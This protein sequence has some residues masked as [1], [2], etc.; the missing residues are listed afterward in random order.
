MAWT[1]SYSYLYLAAAFLGVTAAADL[2]AARL[3]LMP[4]ALLTVAWSRVARPV[5]TRWQTEGRDKELTRMGWGSSVGLE[6]LTLAYVGVLLLS[7]PLLQQYVLGPQY[8]NVGPLL[9]LWGVYFAFNVV[10][11]VSTTWLSSLGEYRFLFGQ[12]LVALALM[13]VGAAAMI[14]TLGAAGA[15]WALIV[16]EATNMVIGW[17]RVLQLRAR[18]RRVA[19]AARASAQR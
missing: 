18:A 5:I 1:A 13:L 14:P 4:V 10:R 12:S 9:G 8:H 3:L 19:P 7:F 17:W 2:N 15:I 16:V 6:V 11:W